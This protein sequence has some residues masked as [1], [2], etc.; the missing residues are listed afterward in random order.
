MTRVLVIEP[1]GSMWGSERAL[2]DLLSALRNINL[3]V[4][5]PPKAPLMDELKKR[6]IRTLPYYVY[7][8]HKKSRRQR[9]KAAV[10]VL[11]ACIEFRPD[12]IYLNQSGSY[13]VSLPSA[14]IFD[15]PIVAHIRIFDDA[16]Y[17]ARQH[18]S[19][20]R[21]RGIIAISSAVEKEVRDYRE[22]DGIS[23]HRIYDGYSPVAPTSEQNMCPQEEVV[24]RIVCIGR[25]APIKGQDVLVS[26]LSLL[27][28][29]ARGECLFGGEGEESF[30]CELKQKTCSAKLAYATR[31]LGFM[32]DVISVLQTCSVMVCPSHREPLGR[33]I[34]EAW[35]AGAVPVVFSHSGGAAEIV[36]AARGGIL[37][38][39]QTPEC[40]ARALQK[41]LAL[42][43][44]DREH[45]LNNGRSWMAEN[46]NPR[47]YGE[48]LSNLLE[49]ACG[50]GHA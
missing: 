33:V 48:K 28:S 16:A 46:C 31:W 42:K 19:P 24:N 49:N 5:C 7:G 23:L 38:D 18:P 43:R 32:P 35:D 39:E 17:L 45:L 11:R 30:V 21:L 20:H 27:E 29:E 8:L 44:E 1:S 2:L 6:Q 47:L 25:I 37:Y 4:C 34:L 3:A 15:L 36:A 41:A 9:L 40:L 26:A 10:G 14:T 22:L 50:Y 13:K 12:V